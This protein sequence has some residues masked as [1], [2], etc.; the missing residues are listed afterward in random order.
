VL[1][2]GERRNIAGGRRVS[3]HFSVWER[4]I[5]APQISP[6]SKQC[7]FWYR[8]NSKILKKRAEAFTPA[9]WRLSYISETDLTSAIVGLA[10]ET[11]Y[12][13]AI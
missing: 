10:H 12:M 1:P 9:L 3:P 6:K 4:I 13:S 11:D 2:R 5:E 8:N 7:R